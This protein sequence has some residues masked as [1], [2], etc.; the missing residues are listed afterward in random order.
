[1]DNIDFFEAQERLARDKWLS[2]DFDGAVTAEKKHGYYGNTAE[3]S[4]NQ[5]YKRYLKWFID[6]YGEDAIEK[7]LDFKNWIEWAAKRGIIKRKERIDNFSATPEEKSEEEKVKNTLM[8]TRRRST[9]TIAV[10]L[11]LFAI[12]GIA[13]ILTSKTK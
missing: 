2:A 7:P 1:M 12:Y 11:T 8:E 9:I 4:A 5:L 6:K 13:K 3:Q 10:I